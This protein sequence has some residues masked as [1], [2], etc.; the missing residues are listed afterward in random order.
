LKEAFRV[1]RIANGEFHAKCPHARFILCVTATTGQLTA[2]DLYQ[3]QRESYAF[4]MAAG[5]WQGKHSLISMGHRSQSKELFRNVPGTPEPEAGAAA[6]TEVTPRP[7]RRRSGQ[8]FL[9][10]SLRYRMGAGGAAAV[11]HAFSSLGWKGCVRRF[12]RGA[13]CR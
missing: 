2:S 11:L 9:S 13:N 7:L 4:V 1:R 8:P 6:L 3:A 5:T 10:Q 12:G